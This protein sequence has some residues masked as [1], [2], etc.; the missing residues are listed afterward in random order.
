MF[1]RAPAVFPQ[2]LDALPERICPK[3]YVELLVNFLIVLTHR[4]RQRDRERQ[5][6]REREMET[7]RERER[8]I[9]GE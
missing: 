1:C 7:E 4:E 6:E 3:S 8:A 9:E 2:S 5:R